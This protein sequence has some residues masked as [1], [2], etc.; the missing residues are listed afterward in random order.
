MFKLM[1]D[2][3]Q[4]KKHSPEGEAAEELEEELEVAR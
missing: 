2:H 3:L 4:V 1:K